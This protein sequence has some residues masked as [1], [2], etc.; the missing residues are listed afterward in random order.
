MVTWVGTSGQDARRGTA[1]A[2]RL[3]G[4]SGDDDLSGLGGDDFL[5]GEAGEDILSG[6]DGSDRL[7]GEVYDPPESG[8][9]NDW[10]RGEGGDDFLNGGPGHD[11]LDGGAGADR[12]NGWTGSDVLYG[13][14]GDDWMD[15]GNEGDETFPLDYPLADRL[16]GGAGNDTLIGRSG[17]DFLDGGAGDDVLDGGGDADHL[18]GGTG[19]DVLNGGWWYLNLLQGGPG[20][21]LY[22]VLSTVIDDAGSVVVEDPGGG[23]DT[24]EYTGDAIGRDGSFYA[25]VENFTVLSGFPM[26]GEEVFTF[27]GNRHDNRIVMH[28]LQDWDIRGLEGDDVLRGGDGPDEILSYSNTGNDSLDGGAGF[29]KLYGGRGADRLDGGE[30]RDDFQFGRPS[31]SSTVDGGHGF[32]RIDAFEPGLDDFVFTGAFDADTTLAGRQKLSFVGQD[33]GPG[34]GELAYR[35]DGGKTFLIA[36]VDG[37]AYSEFQVEILGTVAIGAGDVLVY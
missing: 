2:D 28:D 10:L 26:R 24:I 12:M 4:R 32:D 34:R 33:G 25:E 3:W 19:N 5:Y 36:N 16:Y 9:G 13:Q 20:D 30:G 31:D 11:R 7:Y 14:D 8:D 29:D 15:A 35:N 37:D 17:K 18:Y 21:D 22:E 23:I 27:Q 6:G 1:D